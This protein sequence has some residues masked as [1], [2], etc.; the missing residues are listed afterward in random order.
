MGIIGLGNIGYKI[1]EKCIAAFGM[2]IIYTDID[3][4]YKAEEKLPAQYYESLERMVS[5]CDAVVL[6][7]PSLPKTA[8]STYLLTADIFSC[9][10][11]GSR[12]INIARGSLVESNALADALESKHIA[13]AGLDVF[14]DEPRIN[15]RLLNMSNVEMTCHNGGGAEETWMKFEELAIRNVHLVL[16]GEEPLTAVNGHFFAPG[17]KNDT[18]TLEGPKYEDAKEIRS[19]ETESE[20]TAH[21]IKEAKKEKGARG[22]VLPRKWRLW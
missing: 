8:T 9:F 1:A 19:E 22:R 6:A 21:D 5:E 7:T 16:S 15:E 14:E 12:F 10:K 13:A 11:K 2:K 20:A 18:K 4:K 3:R 17:Q